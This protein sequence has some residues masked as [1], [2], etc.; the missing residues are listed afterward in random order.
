M[1]R[2]KTK[3]SYTPRC[4]KSTKLPAVMGALVPST[5]IVIGE[6]L[7]VITTVAL[8]SSLGKSFIPGIASCV[9]SDTDFA[10]VVVSVVAC[11][12]AFV[13]ASVAVGEG[14]EVSEDTCCVEHPPTNKT[15]TIT[16]TIKNSENFN[17]I[18][19]FYRLNQCI[20]ASDCEDG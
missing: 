15:L 12:V 19:Q 13:L 3:P 9:A 7:T 6:P 5:S 20:L 17:R 18:S 2:W 1:T 10:S 11:V 4:T 8:P 16:N 14:D